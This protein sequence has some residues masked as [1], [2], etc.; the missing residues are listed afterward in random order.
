MMMVQ[1][2][3]TMPFRR[4]G[5]SLQP[6]NSVKHIID[7]EGALSA[8]ATSMNVIADTVNVP[9]DPFNPV[10][11][12]LGAKVNAFFISVFAIGATGTGQTGSINWLLWKRKAGQSA[13]PNPASAGTSILRSQIIHQE[14]GLAGSA[15][16]TPMAFKGVIVIPRGMRRMAAE[17]SW[18]LHLSNTDTTNDV[19]FCVRAIYKSFF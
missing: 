3:V 18:E 6:I 1:V 15:D 13:N 17:D 19:N 16:G 11:V 8:G 4:R 2:T 5:S 12:K 10:E 14:K 9:S 7:S